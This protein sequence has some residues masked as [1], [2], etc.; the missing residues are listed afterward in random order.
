[1]RRLPRPSW[2]DLV[3]LAIL[4]LLPALFWWRL[5]APNPADRMN[6]PAGDF[7]GQYYPLRAYAA[8]ELAAGRLPLWNPAAYGGQPALADIQS[9]ALYPPHVVEALL[10]AGL[11]LCFPVWALEL[12]AIAHFSWAAVGA[13]LLG[14]RLAR[15]SGATLPNARFA[16]AVA[17]LVFTYGGY[18]TGFP[19]QQLTIL[20][21]SAWAPWVLLSIDSLAARVWR[22]EISPPPGPARTGWTAGQGDWR[23]LIGTWLLAGL[24]L[25]L[26]L[27]PGHP[28]T[29]LY[30]VYIVVAFYFFRVLFPS[31][32]VLPEP[33]ADGGQPTANGSPQTAV[34]RPPSAVRSLRSAVTSLL[35]AIGYLLLAL[36]LALALAAAQL[37]PTLEFIAHSPRA[38]LS[39]AAVSFGLPLHE[40][41]ALVYPGYF[42]GSPQYLGVVPMLLIG[43]A[44]ALGRPR[45]EVAFGR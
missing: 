7:T 35:P 15:R 26:S 38:D 23:S 2:P 22:L 27:L 44:L 39:Y 12:Q 45:R 37:L 17:A 36:L 3:I 34:R 18:L 32:F 5:I 41:V 19:V 6:I 10:L 33:T 8:A 14:R 28:Q 42:G 20:E 13:Y 40:L 4:A 43:L 31:S 29:S 24:V 16:G 1:L 11:G 21:V 30:V 25:G 9:G